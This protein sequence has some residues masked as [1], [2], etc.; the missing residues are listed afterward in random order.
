MAYAFRRF[1]FPMVLQNPA[2]DERLWHRC[3]LYAEQ[4]D[5]EPLFSSPA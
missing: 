5:S 2:V 3:E 1:G 4:M